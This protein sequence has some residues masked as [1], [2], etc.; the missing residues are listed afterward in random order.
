MFSVVADGHTFIAG[1]WLRASESGGTCRGSSRPTSE[2]GE[3]TGYEK[4][5]LVSTP[6]DDVVVGPRVPRLREHFFLI[7]LRDDGQCHRSE[8][9]GAVF[10][11]V[12]TV[13]Q[14]VQPIVKM[15]ARFLQI[16]APL[17]FLESANSP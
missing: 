3:F 7:D 10:Q 8:E 13:A 6:L 9:S 4:L 2:V 12:P 5:S 15:L 16:A 11:L 1:T 17:E 14:D